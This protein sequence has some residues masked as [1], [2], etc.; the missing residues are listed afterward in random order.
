[1]FLNLFKRNLSKEEIKKEI[2]ISIVIS[3][4][5]VFVSVLISFLYTPFLLKNV[6]SSEYGVYSFSKS[7]VNWFSVLTAALCS[8][9]IKFAT[10]LSKKDEKELPKLNGIYLIFFAIIS[11]LIFLIT[12][13]ILVLVSNNII[14]FN[15]YTPSEKKLLVPAFALIGLNSVISI[16]VSYFSL[17]E[18]FK[19]RFVWA[20]RKARYG[21]L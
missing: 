16:F 17:H 13:V 19:E 21:V 7:I 4:I 2:V 1:M 14:L 15:E 20:I 10:D 12:V 3:Y 5:T 9:Y 8:G 11:L 6:G 18:A